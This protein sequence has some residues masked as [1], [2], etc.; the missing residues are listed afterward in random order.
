MH[1]CITRSGAHFR[2]L[3]E[4]SGSRTIYAYGP[5]D[6]RAVAAADEEL[7]TINLDEDEADMLANLLHSRPIPDRVAHLERR[8]SEITG[9]EN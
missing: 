3:E 8:V 1:D 7:V 9:E 6:A 2:V 4:S 5:A